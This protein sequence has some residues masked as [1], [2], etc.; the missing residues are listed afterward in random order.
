M[1]PNLDKTLD[2]LDQQLYM[3]RSTLGNPRVIETLNDLT[4]IV[5]SIQGGS[6]KNNIIQI[7]TYI[8]KIK[9]LL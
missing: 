1:N 5:R 7:R 3:S 6:G 2:R 4:E 8:Q 9:A